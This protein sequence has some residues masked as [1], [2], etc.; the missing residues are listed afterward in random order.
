MNEV[1]NLA[2]TKQS[3]TPVSHSRP[4]SKEK[5]GLAEAE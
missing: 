5:A 4:Y 2:G 1:T 3:Q